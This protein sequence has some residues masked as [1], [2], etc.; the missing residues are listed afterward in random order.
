[1]KAQSRHRLHRRRAPARL[2]LLL[3]VVSCLWLPLSATARDMTGKGGLGLLQSSHPQ[4]SRL[5]TLL[6]RYWGEKSCW[7]LLVGFDLV[8]DRSTSSVTY[9]DKDKPQ[10]FMLDTAVPA[11]GASN[12]E[13]KS[14]E[15]WFFDTTH[16]FAGIGWHRMVHGSSSLSLTLGVRAVAQFT[17]TEDKARKDDGD[18]AVTSALALLAE[19]PLQAEFFLS[20]HSSISASVAISASISSSLRATNETDGGLVDLLGTST[21]DRGGVAI[22]LGGRYSGGVGFTYYF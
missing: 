20:D 18:G 3:A 13:I 2:L 4:M 1:M 17:S 11:G 16:I 12:S 7:E 6:F 14:V 8:R 22:Q 15:P 9:D 10:V 21:D 5:P 19:L